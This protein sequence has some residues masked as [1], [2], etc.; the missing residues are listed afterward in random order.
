MARPRP[1]LSPKTGRA[2]VVHKALLADFHDLSAFNV[3][4]S[5]PPAMAHAAR[6]TFLAAGGTENRL[7]DNSFDFAP[8]VPPADMPEGSPR[9]REP[10]GTAAVTHRVARRPH[11]TAADRGKAPKSQPYCAAYH[12]PIAL[13]PQI[14]SL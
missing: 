8:D 2:G 3:Y 12:M 14:A 1:R 4:M 5:G 13:G 11:S 6:T 9:C 7:H 10:A